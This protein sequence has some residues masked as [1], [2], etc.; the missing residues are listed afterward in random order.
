MLQPD[1]PFL[2]PYTAAFSPEYRGDGIEQGGPARTFSVARDDAI[3][4]PIR[5]PSQGVTWF[6]LE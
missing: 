2:S 1:E 6:V 3:G 5:V 4:L